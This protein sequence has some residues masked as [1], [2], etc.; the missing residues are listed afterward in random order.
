MDRGAVHGGVEQRAGPEVVGVARTILGWGDRSTSYIEYGRGSKDGALFPVFVWKERKYYPVILW[1]YGRVEIQF[2]QLQTRPPFD[3][4]EKRRDFLT[5][6][7]AIP[8]ISIPEE[9]LD[10]RPAVSMSVLVPSDARNQ[11]ISVLNWF[12]DEVREKE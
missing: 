11:F 7:N 6:L 9:A 4:I 2:T 8:G 10:K 5:R 1:T 12:L 3:D